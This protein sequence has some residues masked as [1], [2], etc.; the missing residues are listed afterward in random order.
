MEAEGG[1][2]D[3]RHE[4]EFQRDIEQHQGEFPGMANAH[5][6]ELCGVGDVDADQL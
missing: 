2:G 6:L 3:G 5:S 4:A 1:E